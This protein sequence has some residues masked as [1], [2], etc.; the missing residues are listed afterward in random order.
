MKTYRLTILC[1]IPILGLSACSSTRKAAA[2]VKPAPATTAQ[3]KQIILKSVDQRRVRSG[4]FVKTYH[5]GR[6]VSGRNGG[7]LHEAHRVYRLEKPSRWNLARDQPPLA[8]TGPV[9]RVVD[10]AFTPP[11][12]SQAIRAELKRQRASAEQLEQARDEMNAAVATAKARLADASKSADLIAPLQQEIEQLRSENA[13]LRRTQ[14]ATAFRLVHEDGHT[15]RCPAP[16][17]C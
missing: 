8:S 10:S 9:N 6:S 7:T 14:S 11:P 17:G 2:P 4:E 15:G 16:V 5:V 12:E 1:L 3:G 13:S